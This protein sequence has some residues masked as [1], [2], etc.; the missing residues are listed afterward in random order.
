MG[1]S[2]AERWGVRLERSPG[3]RWLGVKGQGWGLEFSSEYDRVNEQL[4]AG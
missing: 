2:R 1:M 4:K 3:A